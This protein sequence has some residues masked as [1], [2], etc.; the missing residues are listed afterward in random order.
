VRE[1]AM[2]SQ[3]D[4]DYLVDKKLVKEARNEGLSEESYNRYAANVKKAG[5]DPPPP[6]YVMHDGSPDT[7]DP[8]PIAYA[9]QTKEG[10]P[11][12]M[13]NEAALRLPPDQFAAYVGGHEIDHIHRGDVTPEG[14]AAMMN[15]RD[16]EKSIERRADMEGAL[17]SCDPK[18]LGDALAI[19][20]KLDFELYKKDY[21]GKGEKDFD[22]FMAENEP[23][24]PPTSER[25][26]ALREFE[27]HI[28][29]GADGVCS[30]DDYNS[31]VAPYVAKAVTPGDP[32]KGR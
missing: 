25:I 11:Y 19:A 5:I 3:D 7:L 10:K 22:K 4:I 1:H 15:N 24:H 12:V 23:H 32:A 9:R 17:I 27:K 20:K 31:V 29:K 14:F 2:K 6:V 26:A 28:I 18:A 8:A 13:I 16:L 21:P 30:V